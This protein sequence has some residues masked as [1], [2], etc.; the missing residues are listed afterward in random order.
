MIYVDDLVAHPVSAYHD[1]QAR[2]VGAKN[3]DRWCHLYA[4]TPEEL[5]AAA[6]RIG[7]RR[8][9]AQTSRTGVEHYDLTPGRRAHAVAAGARELARHEVMVLVIRP[10]RQRLAEQTGRAS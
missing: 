1:A 4:D 6:A 7:M 9:W 5:H 2:R 8:S 10:Q 3:G